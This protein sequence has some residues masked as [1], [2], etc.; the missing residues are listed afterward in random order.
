MWGDEQK[1]SGE[2]CLDQTSLLTPYTLT[3]QG[4]AFLINKWQQCHDASALDRD[5]QITLLFSSQSGDP[6]GQDFPTLGNEFPEQ[7]NVFVVDGFAGFDWRKAALVVTHDESIGKGSLG[8][9]VGATGKNLP[10]FADGHELFNFFVN[11]ML[12]AVCAEL[13]E[14]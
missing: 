3:P 8:G 14:F 13:L 11:R 4:L 2:R 12:V 6:T 10:A 1:I 9:S 5:S 7:I